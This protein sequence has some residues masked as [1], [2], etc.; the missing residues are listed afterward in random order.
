MYSP[1]AILVSGASSG[2]GR[3]IALRYAREGVTLYLTGRNKARLLE[4]VNASEKAGAKALWKV[5]D[6]SNQQQVQSWV[7]EIEE[8]THWIWSYPM[9]VLQ[10]HMALVGPLNPQKLRIHRS[11]P[12]W[13]VPSIY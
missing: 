6:I 4:T 10:V 12:I 7:A 5:L 2:V 13:V 8:Q 1:K 11:R 3:A 9:P